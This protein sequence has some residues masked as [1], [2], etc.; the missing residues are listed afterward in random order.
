[1]PRD[2]RTLPCHCHVC[3]PP[4]QST[5]RQAGIT[6]H[7]NS[8]GWSAVGVREGEHVPGWGYSIGL[9]HTHRSFELAVFGLPAETCMRLINAAGDLV[10]QGSEFRPGDHVDDVINNYPVAVKFI[11]N[12]WYGDLFGQAL[13]FYQQPPLAFLQLVWPD[14]QHRFPWDDGVDEH[15]RDVQPQLWL[16]HDEHPDGPWRRLRDAEPW[17]FTGGCPDDVVYTT[18][19]VMAGETTVTGVVHDADGDWQF[20]DGGSTD[21]GDAVL[22]HLRHVVERQPH[23]VALADLPEGSQAWQQ[24]DGRWVRFPH[25]FADE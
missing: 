4:A 25:A 2:L 19:R 10:K 12:S 15:C 3:D 23:V 24:N 13:D 21:E 20:L 14:K 6:G 17:L 11:H 7:V 22:V 18:K 5:E 1:M 8:H 9:W 16:P